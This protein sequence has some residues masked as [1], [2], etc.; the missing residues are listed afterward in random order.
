ML[1]RLTAIS[2]A[3]SVVQ[4]TDFG[5]KLISRSIKLYSSSDG[6]N[7]DNADLETKIEHARKLAQR[8][9]L[10]F[11]NTGEPTSRDEEELRH[12]PKSCEVIALDLLSILHDLKVKKP[13]GPS[14]VWESFRKVVAAQTPWNKKKIAILSKRLHML[15]KS[16][17]QQVHV[18]MR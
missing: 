12:L 14:R 2:L 15:Q 6:V 7:A 4:L 3:S 8:V 16:M 17:F 5:I 1:D 11:D 13:A 10:A 18:M 9:M